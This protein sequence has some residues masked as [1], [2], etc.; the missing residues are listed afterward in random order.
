M[1]GLSGRITTSLA[2]VVLRAR[3]LSQTVPLVLAFILAIIELCLPL[4]KN[5]LCHDLSHWRRTERYARIVGNLSTFFLILATWTDGIIY[6]HFYEQ[7]YLY[8]YIVWFIITLLLM[9]S[10]LYVRFNVQAISRAMAPIIV[11][12]V[13]WNPTDLVAFTMM[14]VEN[15][16]HLVIAIASFLI[17]A[18][19]FIRGRNRRSR[20]DSF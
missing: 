12:V 15:I 13:V 4:E 19:L 5:K 3:V 16:P 7:Q 14:V 11:G 9:F 1:L 10:M 18:A 17:F 6:S 2:T 8:F 20:Y